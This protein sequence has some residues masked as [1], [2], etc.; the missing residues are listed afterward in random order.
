MLMHETDERTA[1]VANFLNNDRL[2]AEIGA[3]FVSLNDT[4]CVYEYHAG[5]SHHN[6]NGMLHGGALFTVMDS[7]QGMLVCSL[8]TEFPGPPATG[9]ATIKYLRPVFSGRILIRTTL[10]RSGGRKLFVHSDATDESGVTVAEMDQVWIYLL[11]SPNV[12]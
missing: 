9:T 11:R 2:A 1:Y 10:T 5:P 6:P 7:S 12:P 8:K 3:R 4:E